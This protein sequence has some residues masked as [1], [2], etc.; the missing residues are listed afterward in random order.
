MANRLELPDELLRLIE[1]RESEGRRASD[2]PEGAP[3]EAAPDEPVAGEA[4]P[5]ERRRVKDR[6]KR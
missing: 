2:T 1:K 3:N 5:V 4:P 6:R